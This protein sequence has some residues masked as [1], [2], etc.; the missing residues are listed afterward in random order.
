MKRAAFTLPM[1]ASLLCLGGMLG[2]CSGLEEKLV[3]PGAASQGQAYATIPPSADYELIPLQTVD[4]TRIVAQFGRALGPRGEPMP[5]PTRAPTVIFFYGNGA[6][7]AQMGNEFGH[8][9]RLGMNVLIPEYPGYGMSGGKPGERAFYSA[10]DAAYDY[11]LGRPGIDRERIVA[12]GWSMGSA[13]AIDLASR[14]R[15]LAV[16]TV[17][18]FT[19]LPAVAHAL[20]PWMPVS[21]IIRSR[22][23]NLGKIPAVTCPI[24]IIHGDRD[25]IVPPNMAGALAAAAKARVTSYTVEGGGHNDVFAVGGDALWGA[26]GTF[27]ASSK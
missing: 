10:A 24:M 21:L 20:Q 17:S 26:V 13:V 27:L 12:A 8:F 5:V 14:R 16:V 3:F 25:E 9:R 2:G 23:D 1:A 6:F 18:A 19:T 7:A 22:F 4:G 11:L 15:V